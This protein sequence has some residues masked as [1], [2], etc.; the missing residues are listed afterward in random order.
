[1]IAKSKLFVAEDMI[2]EA[3]IDYLPPGKAKIA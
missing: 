2:H 1:M 3:S